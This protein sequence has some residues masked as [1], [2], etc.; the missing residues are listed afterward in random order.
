MKTFTEEDLRNAF[1]AGRER[2]VHEER[3]NY[4]DAPLDEDEYIYSLS[5]VMEEEKTI[6]VTLGLIKATCG[7]MKF[8][9]VTG[10]NHY[11]LNEWSVEDTE[12]FKIKESHAKELGF[13]K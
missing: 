8:C 12:V 6:P 4:F 7:W 1:K 13:I 9:D 3:G 5:K 2:G 10:S 11:M